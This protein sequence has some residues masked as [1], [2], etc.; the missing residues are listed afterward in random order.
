MSAALDRLGISP[1]PW[2]A[3]HGPLASIVYEARPAAE[4]A[5]VCAA[6]GETRKED[7]ALIAAAPDLYAA[8]REAVSEDCGNCQARMSDD[9][10][11]LADGE[12]FVQ[13][14]RKALA[15]AQGEAGA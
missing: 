14:W 4:R 3:E 9:S 10:C 6:T 7:A 1:T 2:T 8:L 11:G 12:C 15:K 5:S 13:R